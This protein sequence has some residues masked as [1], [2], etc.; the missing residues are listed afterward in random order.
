M[1]M[2][3]IAITAFVGSHFALSHPLRAPLVR[4]LGQQGFMLVY[5]LVA[6]ATLGWTAHV[7]QAMP[8]QPLLW[9][10][11]DVL[12]AAATVLMLFA[13][14]LFVG[15]LIG[16]PA[17]PD[18]KATAKPV[19]AARGV[20]AITRHPMMWSFAIWALVHIAI[21]PTPGN[22]ALC[23]GILV[24]ALLGSAL[25]DRKKRDLQPEFWPQWQ[26]ATSYW[27][28]G[29]IAAGRTRLGGF[30]GHDLAGGVVVWLVATWAHLP[31]AGWA[32][33]I[34]RWIG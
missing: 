28:F 7:Y 15:S 24:L 12:W 13:S 22:I 2:L 34:W 29:A 9:P 17:L 18:P 16:N 26:S 31:L 25:Q 3:I 6:F 4:A 32:A 33:G 14:V 11:G 8:A 21:Y 20:F 27:P 23:L 5:A 30:R 19:P 1:S 10:V